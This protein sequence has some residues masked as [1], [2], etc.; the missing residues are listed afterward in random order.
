M[1][2]DVFRIPDNGAAGDA[3]AVQLREIFVRGGAIAE[4]LDN[5]EKALVEQSAGLF[6]RNGGLVRPARTAIA[7]RD[8]E[9]VEDLGLIEVRA[10]GLVEHITRAANLLK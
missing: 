3:P 8:G 2:V 7:V 9:T 6:Q 10:T 1:T 4:N 5:I